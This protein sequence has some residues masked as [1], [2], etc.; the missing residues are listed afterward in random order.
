VAS[1][2]QNPN[3][4]PYQ[5]PY[6]AFA[7]T[8]ITT[9]TQ[10]LFEFG[11][12]L[13]QTFSAHYTTETISMVI[14]QY[15]PWLYFDV[16]LPPI[17]VGDRIQLDFIATGCCPGGHFSEL[18]VDNVGQVPQ[19]L[20]AY[21][22]TVAS[23]KIG[24]PLFYHLFVETPVQVSTEVTVTLDLPGTS[25]VSVVFPG[26]VCSSTASQL[27]CTISGLSAG[28]YNVGVVEI[29]SPALAT[30]LT[31]SVCV[32]AGQPLCS[33]IYPKTVVHS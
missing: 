5:E 31:P 29:V 6:F 19:E 17:T 28:S 7:I 25:V 11:T 32:S 20:V 26:W 2:L 3:H 21:G 24:A 22:R 16:L 8:D 9:N 27:T 23:V 10:L 15:T 13:A 1:V 14:Y 4:L 30:L 33:P 12:P 18:Y